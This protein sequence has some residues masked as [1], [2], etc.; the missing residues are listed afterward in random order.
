MTRTPSASSPLLCI[1]H[2]GGR[3]LGEENTLATIEKGLA[4]GADAIE[5]DVWSVAGE[6]IVTH[7]RYLG[8]VI[9]GEGR[10]M[11]VD[12][13]GLNN[14]RTLGDQP[15]PT[16]Q[17]VITVV[18]D[19][20]RLNIELKGPRCAPQVA[21]QVL[22]FCRDKHFDIEQ[23]IISSF[24]HQQL[25]WLYQHHPQLLRGALICHIPLD[26]AQCC[27]ALGAYSFHP[28]VDFITPELVDDAHKRNAKVW[29]YT[30]NEE[31]DFAELSAMGVEGVFTD[32][33]DRLLAFNKTLSPSG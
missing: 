26:Y 25:Y 32:Y 5:I 24:D 2:R 17:Q 29:V 12:A 33:P 31:Q 20:A 22:S 11:D 18:G 15:V 16:L 8:R 6:L 27:D 3:T 4:L 28:N 23:Y 14:L 19:R 10:L 9:K 13:E 7:D 21:E 1:A 30:V